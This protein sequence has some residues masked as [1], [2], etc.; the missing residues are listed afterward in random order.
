MHALMP[1]H[2]ATQRATLGGQLATARSRHAESA[3]RAQI[4]ETDETGAAL[5]DIDRI[6]GQLANLDAARSF[7]VAVEQRS[8]VDARAIA[9]RE[10][11]SRAHAA[12]ADAATAAGEL[13]ELLARVRAAYGALT[14][15]REEAHDAVLALVSDPNDRVT[16]GARFNASYVTDWLVGQL[17]A[18]GVPGID[19]V[20]AISMGRL[21]GNES[22]ATID[23]TRTAG[24]LAQAARPAPELRATREGGE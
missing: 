14:Q 17:V 11:A 6:E 16:V 5:A 13:D 19:D 23:A 10:W 9:R 15:A 4:G 8:I 21:F 7:A 22:L 24:V 3:Y 12:F 20:N 18:A 2:L 1:D